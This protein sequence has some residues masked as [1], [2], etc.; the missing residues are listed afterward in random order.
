MNCR[1]AK[2]SALPSYLQSLEAVLG[3]TPTTTSSISTE[4]KSSTITTS[5]S[6]QV[7]QALPSFLTSPQLTAGLTT[8]NSGSTSGKLKLLVVGTHAHQFTG[9]S[10]ITYGIIKELAKNPNVAVTHFGFQKNPQLPPGYRPYPPNIR[11]LDAADMEQRSLPPNTPPQQGFGFHVLPDVIRHEKPN[12]VLVYND[13]AVVAR[14]L[15]E[16]RKSGITRNFKIWVYADQVYNCQHQ[17]FLDILNRDADRV[18]AF[19][20]YWRKC[21]KDQGITRPIDILGHG[22]EKE[23]FTTI[24]RLEV[25]K[26]LGLPP[27][28]FIIS[29]LNR[30]QP[31]KRYDLLVMAFVE[32][33]VKYPTKPIFL[34]CICDKGEKGGWWLFEIYARELKLRGVSIEKFANRLMLSSQDMSFR[35][36]DINMFYNL[37]DIGINTADGEGWGLCNFEQMGVGVP[38]VVPDV[39]GFKEFCNNN[40]SVVVKPKYRFYQPTVHCPVGGESEAC[41]PHDICLGIE[42]YLLNT[43]KRK[44]HGEEAKKTVL[45]YTWKK[46]TENLMKRLNEEHKEM[47]ENDD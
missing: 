8:S 35:D 21:L 20:K 17:G 10:K 37:A 31:R 5:V 42:E 4:G 24:P 11:V 30:N 33:I 12:V 15:E 43:E 34:M 3:G 2:M 13:M 29:A 45:E 27:E 36:E 41:D 39:G 6:S 22:F 23:V 32:L 16:I 9:Y 25:R 38:Q 46:A 44:K 40:N 19:T 26:K 14:F 1:L 47:T 28:A 7:S 18:F